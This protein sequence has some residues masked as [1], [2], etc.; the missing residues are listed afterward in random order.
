[1]ICKESVKSNRGPT[2]PPPRFPGPRW[3]LCRVRHSPRAD[4][5]GNGRR[6]T[7]RATTPS[8]PE[9]AR[10]R[11]SGPFAGTHSQGSRSAAACPV[12]CEFS[13]PEACAKQPDKRESPSCFGG[14]PVSLA[15]SGSAGV[16]TSRS[17]LPGFRN[18]RS[19]RPV[20]P[21][22][23]PAPTRR[24]RA[25]LREQSALRDPRNSWLTP[26]TRL[27]ATS[28]AELRLKATQALASASAE[29]CSGIAIIVGNRPR[30][31]AVAG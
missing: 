3:D 14:T 23:S 22:T 18:R 12:V 25:C 9:I 4:R 28:L 6:G 20:M 7:W 31:G 10:L 8:L 11:R 19:R 15:G 26:Q 30:P 21:A 2:E 27:E 1:M 29:A 16:A 5:A 17:A 13:E 24:P